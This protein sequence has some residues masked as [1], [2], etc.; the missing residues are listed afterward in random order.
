MV[1]FSSFATGQSKL[2]S[3]ID[4]IIVSRNFRGKNIFQLV[5]LVLGSNHELVKKTMKPVD[6]LFYFD[7]EWEKGNSLIIDEAKKDGVILYTEKEFQDKM[8]FYICLTKS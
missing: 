4:L 3:D 7:E 8:N 1:F 2:E 6:I 5:K